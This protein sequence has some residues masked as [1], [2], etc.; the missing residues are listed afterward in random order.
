[1]C[2]SHSVHPFLD[3]TILPY[4]ILKI[5]SR[6]LIY[7][8]LEYVIDNYGRIVKS[9]VKK[10]LFSLQDYQEE[11]INDVFLAVWE[12]IESYRPMRSSFVN[13]IAGIARYKAIDY[14][15]KYLK[16]IQTENLEDVTAGEE[17][18]EQMKMIEEELSEEM[19]E[20]LSCLSPE[21]R[22]LFMKLYVEEMEPEEVSRQ[23]GMKKDVI[24]NRVS[25]GRRKIRKLFS[26][27]KGEKS[28]EQ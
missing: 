27:Q 24:Y 2:F 11:C 20:M 9:I 5:Y 17:D 22:E 26:T 23:T 3:N 19:E 4:I 13:W 10:H 8:I 18:R 14:K 7:S 25:R 16:R 6:N 21:D 15:R 28:Y 12:N 1:M